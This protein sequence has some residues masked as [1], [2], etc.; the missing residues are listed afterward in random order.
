MKLTAT[1]IAR[2]LKVSRQTVYNLLA[3]KALK[4]QTAAGLLAYTEM[5]AASTAAAAKAAKQQATDLKKL[6]KRS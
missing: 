6:I 3:T 5:Q 1:E 4:E 2:L